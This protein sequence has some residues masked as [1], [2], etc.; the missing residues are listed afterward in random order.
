MEKDEKLYDDVYDYI[1]SEYSVGDYINDFELKNKLERSGL[2]IETNV[3]L[4]TAIKTT[5]SMKFANVALLIS[6]EEGSGTM[7]EEIEKTKGSDDILVSDDVKFHESIFDY[8]VDNY[9]DGDVVDNEQLTADLEEITSV[10]IE[11]VEKDMYIV[12]A[13]NAKIEIS[14]REDFE[15]VI[16]GIDKYKNL[17][18][19]LVDKVVN[20]IREDLEDG[21]LAKDEDAVRDAS[22]NEAQNAITHEN[23]YQVIKENELEDPSLL[24]C[25]ELL[26]GEYTSIRGVIV[27]MAE[28]IINERVKNAL[29]YGEQALPFLE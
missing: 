2:E 4:S 29:L 17:T 18:N 9:K 6:S 7:I 13:G 21:D 11:S 14:I 8:V 3:I 15:W 16:T 1:D 10:S 25:N 19:Q 28:E 22:W 20:I 23:L 24:R 5:Y 12:Y 26:I 27:D